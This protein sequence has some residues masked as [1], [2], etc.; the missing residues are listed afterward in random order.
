[1]FSYVKKS[2]MEKAINELRIEVLTQCAKLAASDVMLAEQ[3]KS[4][5]DSDIK[6]AE[7]NLKTINVLKEIVK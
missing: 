3:L 1:M 4:L 6:M 5:S 2:E 7:W